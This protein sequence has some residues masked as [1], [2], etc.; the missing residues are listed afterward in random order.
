[1]PAPQGSSTVEPGI[2]PSSDIV[3]GPY[4]TWTDLANECGISRLWG[5]VHFSAAIAAGRPIGKAIGE[6]AYQYVKKHIDGNAPP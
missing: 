3:V 2:T 1:M 6:I 5:G 4:A